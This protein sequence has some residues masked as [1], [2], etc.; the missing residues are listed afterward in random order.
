VAAAGLMVAGI[1]LLG[2]LTATYASWLIEEVAVKELEETADLRTEV[3]ALHAKLDRLLVQQE[4][5][6][7][8]AD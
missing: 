4:G 1:A 5:E 3:A 7:T 8:G 2:V 6:V